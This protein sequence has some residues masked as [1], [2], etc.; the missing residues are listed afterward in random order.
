M[1]KTSD[2]REIGVIKQSG[3]SCGCSHQKYPTFTLKIENAMFR[4]SIQ[5]V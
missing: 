3:N 4:G 5:F 1:S 2:M